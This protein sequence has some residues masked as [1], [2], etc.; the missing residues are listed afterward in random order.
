MNYDYNS[1][2]GK[3]KEELLFMVAQLSTENNMFRAQ[4]D[5]LTNERNK[6]FNKSAG[7]DLPDSQKSAPPKQN[8]Q[9]N[10]P[11]PQGQPQV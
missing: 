8:P 5:R 2:Q 9:Q 7:I 3:S 1:L 11:K 6:L 4:I 10:Q